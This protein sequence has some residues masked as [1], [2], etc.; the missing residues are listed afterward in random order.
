[1]DVIRLL[2]A[3]MPIRLLSLQRG[4]GRWFIWASEHVLSRQRHLH[5]QAR[6]SYKGETDDVASVYILNLWRVFQ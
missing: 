3:V 4:S 1:M 2:L 6:P 5:S